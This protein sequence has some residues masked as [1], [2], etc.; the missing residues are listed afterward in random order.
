[1]PPV[2]VL[3]SETDLKPF[4]DEEAQCTFIVAK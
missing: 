1:M 3:R 4:A 2:E